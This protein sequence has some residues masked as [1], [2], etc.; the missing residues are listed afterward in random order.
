MRGA[1]DVEVIGRDPELAALRA[2][3]ARVQRQQAQIVVLEG[4]AGI[5]KSRLAQ[6]VT[7][8]ASDQGFSLFEGACEAFTR[9]DA[10]GALA[11]ALSVDEMPRRLS[12]PGG[13]YVAGAGLG[14]RAELIDSLVA[15]VTIA[16]GRKPTLLVLEDVHWAAEGT[17]VAVR[18]IA[19][20]AAALPLL[21]LL[22][23]RPATSQAVGDGLRLLAG[24]GA[25]LVMLEPRAAVLA[26]GWR[27]CSRARPAI[28]SMRSSSF[29]VCSNVARSSRT[30]ASPR[31]PMTCCRPRSSSACCTSCP[32]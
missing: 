30:R 12:T 23:T 3:L 11:A 15:T 19:Q 20:R 26:R 2:A 4:E 8:A 27:R 9:E 16:A 21:I 1:G 13:S 17:F 18:L 24:A 7:G 25:E 10:F 6:A 28:R 5:G 31:R 32:T 14:G 22:T 29:A